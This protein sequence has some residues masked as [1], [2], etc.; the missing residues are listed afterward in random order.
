LQ[1]YETRQTNDN[2]KQGPLE[3]E[4]GHLDLHLQKQRWQIA[5]PWQGLKELEH[6]GIAGKIPFLFLQNLIANTYHNN[7]VSSCCCLLSNQC[8]RTPWC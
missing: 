2:L 5:S 6:C 1:N 3:L 7:S 4:A 8:H